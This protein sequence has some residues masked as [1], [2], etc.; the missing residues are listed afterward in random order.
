MEPK[1]FRM[2]WRDGVYRVSDPTLPDECVAT[3]I[4]DPAIVADR[5]IAQAARDAGL[6]VDGK[7]RTILGTLEQTED[8]CII[9]AGARLWL[10]LPREGKPDVPA[11]FTVFNTVVMQP[12]NYKP[13]NNRGWST[14]SAAEAANGGGK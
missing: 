6:V 5:A 1:T 4:D 13:R 7:L 10:M 12:D 9:G 3:R 2:T 11:V 14:R 8:G